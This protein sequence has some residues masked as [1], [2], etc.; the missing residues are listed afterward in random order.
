MWLL[1]SSFLRQ[2]DFELFGSAASDAHG[3]PGHVAG[4]TAV[5][6]ALAMW[7]IPFELTYQL[8]RRVEDDH[9]LV[10]IFAFRIQ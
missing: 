10:Q 8:A 6:L 9:A 5:T 3:G 4:G 2:I 7:R 1:P